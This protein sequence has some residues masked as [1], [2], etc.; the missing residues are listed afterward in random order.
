M[1]RINLL[2]WRQEL[3]EQQQK[4]FIITIGFSV[5]MTIVLIIVVHIYINGLIEH[6][7]RRNQMVE[8][9]IA[10]VNTKI[11]KIKDI[12]K[13]KSKL[14]TKIE[15]IQQL[16]ESRPEIVHLFHEVA[17]KLPDGVHLSKF[18]QAGA[19]LKFTGFAQSNARISAFMRAIESS[20]W[21]QDPELDVIRSSK[22]TDVEQQSEF[23]VAARLG[24]KRQDDSNGGE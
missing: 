11:E 18:N 6:Q 16:Q 21:L 3:K 2:P 4:N 14:L 7:Q 13:K 15:V 23:L 24:K 17:E 1:A 9:E 10:I 20:E 5:A 12:E 8:V 19:E 22:K